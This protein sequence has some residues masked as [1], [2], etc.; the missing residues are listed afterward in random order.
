[1]RSA[2]AHEHRSPPSAVARRLV[3]EL[4]PAFVAAAVVISR[5]NAVPSTPSAIWRPL[6]VTLGATA[7]LLLAT[8]VLTRNRFFAAILTST[9]VLFSFREILPAGVLMAAL[10]WAA[11]MQ[12]IG[13]RIWRGRTSR[14]LQEV[15]RAT[16]VIS[17]TTLL[18]T[19]ATAA[20]QF[21]SGPRV[22]APSFI[23]SGSGGPNVYMLMLDGYPRAD[24]LATTFEFDNGAFLDGLESR[25]FGV[26]EAARSNYRK[27]WV[28]LATMFNGTYVDELIAG[29]DPPPT[30]ND[31]IRWLGAMIGR[32][33]VLDPFRMRGYRIATIPSSFTSAALTTADV[34][35]DSG[36][37]TELEANILNRSPWSL[38]FRDPVANMLAHAHADAVRATFRL[39]AE[40]AESR[41]TEPTLLFAHVLSPHTPFVVSERDETPTL[42]ACFPRSCSVW[43]ATMDELGYSFDEYREGFV[44]EVSAVNALVLETADRVIAADPSAVIIVM[45]DHG[46]RYTFDD[47]AEHFRSFFAARVPGMGS[48]F[49]DDESPVNVFRRLSAALFDSGTQPLPYEAWLS[50]WCCP[51][52]VSP[53]D[54]PG[55]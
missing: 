5:F 17:A 41:T 3:I 31:Q 46:S 40:I 29:Q 42:A 4:Q 48:L 1:M 19:V 8:R 12:L 11:I 15:A 13:N 14:R 18:V 36:A 7:L 9:I 43:S 55:E 54:P 33:A 35:Y 2:V 28:T 52:T 6:I 27:T 21:S 30:G 53:Y 23:V 26:A 47:D 16:A 22:L 24:T 37:I 51:L 25:G 39:T 32:S 45:S 10:I 34:T 50:E 49:P 44:D 38:V 20:V